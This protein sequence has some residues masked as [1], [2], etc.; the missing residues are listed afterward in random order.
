MFARDAAAW[1]RFVG[2]VVSVWCCA[3]TGVAAEWREVFNPYRVIS[4]NLELPPADW[5]RVRMDQ[6]SQSEDWV[7]EFAEANFWAEGETPIRVSIRRKGQSDTPLPEGNP[8]KVSLKI[9]INDPV[10]GQKWRGLTKLSLENGSTDPLNEGFAW[11]AHRLAT[12]M[13]GYEAANVAWVKL[14]INGEFKGVFVNVEQRNT[15]F[16]QN[17]DY[18]KEGATWLYK[19]DGSSSLESGIGHSATHNHLCY[20][21]FNSGPGGG[22][23]GNGGCTQP[24][25]EIDLPMWINLRGFFTLAAVDAFVENTD[26]LFSHSGKNSYAVDFD[27]PYPRTRLY[28]PWDLDTTIRQGDQSIYGSEAYQTT[29]L[30]HPW[31]GQVYEATLREL[32]AGPF[33]EQ[34]LHQTINE[35]EQVLKPALD[36]DPYVYGGNSSG[37]FDGLRQWAT[38][39]VANVR[40]QLTKPI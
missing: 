21:P 20:P 22:G 31:F 2:L 8:Q 19:V 25:L 35:L 12:G 1:S 39:R 38:R 16:L 37:A 36:A 33:S 15:Q 29:F 14:H 18:Y 40:T 9:D 4:L 7:P 24:N 28:F 6:P 23:G 3:V 17:H 10:L 5:D 34:A 32:L 13:Y 30:N 11:M 27:P 26:A